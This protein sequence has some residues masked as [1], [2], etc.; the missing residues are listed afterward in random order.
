MEKKTRETRQIQTF[1][2]THLIYTH[3]ELASGFAC[4]RDIMWV[5]LIP[6][7]RFRGKLASGHDVCVARKHTRR[8]RVPPTGLRKA[9]DQASVPSVEGVEEVGWG[10]VLRYRI[11]GR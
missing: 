8:A 3:H 2:N 6:T 10:R 9:S 4:G 1:T 7:S 5:L 11:G